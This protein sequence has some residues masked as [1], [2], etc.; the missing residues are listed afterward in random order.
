MVSTHMLTRQMPQCRRRKIRDMHLKLSVLVP[1][2]AVG[3]N[4]SPH[5]GRL[6]W[7]QVVAGYRNP[8]EGACQRR[9]PP[10]AWEGHD[11]AVGD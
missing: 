9:N 11:A 5:P 6:G 7:G 8:E 3:G 1:R 4:P 10:E 2:T